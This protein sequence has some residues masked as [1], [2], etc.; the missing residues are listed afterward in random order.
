VDR[1]VED[2]DWG[3]ASWEGSR[4]AQVR[5][6]MSLTVRERLEMLEDMARFARRMERL[7]SA[8]QAGADAPG[9]PVT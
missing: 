5:R 9:A 7:R 1:G 3:V 2:F 6:W 4:R 8:P